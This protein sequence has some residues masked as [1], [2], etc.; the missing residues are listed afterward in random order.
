[1]PGQDDLVSSLGASNQHRQLLKGIGS[2]GQTLY[3]HL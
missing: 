2:S 3:T 1:M